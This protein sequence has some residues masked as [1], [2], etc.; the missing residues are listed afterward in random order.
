MEITQQ[1][2]VDDKGK[3]NTLLIIKYT[4]PF[5]NSK[6]FVIVLISRV[7]S[8]L[9]AIGIKLRSNFRHTSLHRQYTGKFKC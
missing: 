1:L 3:N 8:F 6:N 9:Y 5:N 2:S 4:T 7:N